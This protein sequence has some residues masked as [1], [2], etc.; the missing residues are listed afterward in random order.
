M[1]TGNEG[2]LSGEKVKFENDTLAFSVYIENENVG[3][4]LKLNDKTKMSGKAVYSG[5]E[6]LLTLTRETKKK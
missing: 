4:K 3:I 5:G 1:F 2:K 6:V